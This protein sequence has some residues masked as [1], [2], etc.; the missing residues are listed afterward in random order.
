MKAD[1]VNVKAGEER[2][3]AMSAKAQLRHLTP[4][5]ARTDRIIFRL[6]HAANVAATATLNRLDSERALDPI[7]YEAA[8]SLNG[9][10]RLL[11]RGHLSRDAIDQANRAVSEWLSALPQRRQTAHT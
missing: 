8:K 7:R 11:D 9:V 6:R 5:S 4:A 3:A 10:C 2:K 1:K